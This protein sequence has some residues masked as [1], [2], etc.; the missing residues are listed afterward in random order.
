MVTELVARA[1]QHLLSCWIFDAP[2]LS[3]MKTSI[4]RLFFAIGKRSYISYGT[5]FYA[6]HS[7][8]ESLVRIGDRVGI[9]HRCDIDYSGG[10]TIGNNVWIS[11]NV[12]IVTHK[13][14]IKR[15][16][17]KKSQGVEFKGLTIGDDAW[18]GASCIVLSGVS[19]IGKGA[20]VGA[21]AVVTKDVDDWAVVAGNP[22]Q[23]IS[24][25]DE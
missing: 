4:L 19:H 10:I 6:P 18:L 8:N 21:G 12:M 20:V 22:A 3:K 13:H 5:I 11:E 2:G 23:E 14:N 7:S 9:E 24:R 16:R 15:K 25:R 1:T 17:T